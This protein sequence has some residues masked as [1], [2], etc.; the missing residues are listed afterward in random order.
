MNTTDLAD[1]KM[2]FSALFWRVF[3]AGYPEYASINRKTES[4]TEELSLEFSHFMGL[5][6]WAVYQSVIVLLL[7]N[8]LI[9]MMN[10]TYTRVWEEADLHWNYSKSFYQVK[11]LKPKAVFPAPFTIFYY[12]A[13]LMR[14]IKVKKNEEISEKQ[15]QDMEDEN[16]FKL[17][18]RLLKKKR[19]ADYDSSIKEEFSDLR[20]DIQNIVNDQLKVLLREL[21]TQK[22]KPYNV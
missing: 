17:L 20:K 2:V 18:R 14:V 9:A 8:I 4:E 21:K 3:S 15:A 5:V 22:S 12:F 13:K 11:F 16:Y 6:L 7:I 19:H 10:T 1:K